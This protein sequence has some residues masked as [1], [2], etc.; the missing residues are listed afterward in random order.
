MRK[1]KTLDKLYT[2]RKILRQG[3]NSL[4]PTVRGAVVESLRTCGKPNCKC[5]RGEKHKS[6]YFTR[7]VHS[8]TFRFYL[9]SEVVGEI[10]T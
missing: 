6:N 3:L 5:Q 8:K 9:P 10:R 4:G 1:K 7:S 2:Q